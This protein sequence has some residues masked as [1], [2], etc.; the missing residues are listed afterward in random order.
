MGKYVM[1]VQSSAKEG[2]DDEYNE[3]YDTIHA[4]EICSVPGI[5]TCRRLKATPIAIPTPGAAYIS[6]Y[7]IETDNIGALMTE[8]GRRSA[9]GE[10]TPTDSLDKSSAALWIYEDMSLAG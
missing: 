6:L 7:E 4:R 1:V 3:W 8:M 2:R 9:A 5:L 10:Q